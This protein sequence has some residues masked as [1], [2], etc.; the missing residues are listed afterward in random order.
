[1]TAS[2]AL[3]ASDVV[4]RP[5]ASR[6]FAAMMFA[7]QFT[8]ATPLLLLPTAPIV[9]DT[10]VPWAWSSYGSHRL[11]GGGFVIALKPCVPAGHGVV[12]PLIVTLN[13]P[14]GADHTLAARSE[15]V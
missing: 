14:G 15:C 2:I 8:P 5:L 10:C 9:P 1:M 11:S 3:I 4:P 6:N 12:W 13:P 7:V